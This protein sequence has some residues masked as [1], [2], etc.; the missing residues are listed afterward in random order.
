MSRPPSDVHPD[1]HDGRALRLRA[2]TGGRPTLLFFGYTD[3]PDICP[4]TMADV[5]VALRGL[6]PATAAGNTARD[7]ADD[8][9]K[10]VATA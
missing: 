5:A 10:V 3:C 4:A 2:A 7:I 1:R 9:R 8:L 6:D